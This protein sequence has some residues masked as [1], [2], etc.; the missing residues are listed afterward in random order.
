MD[1]NLQ[2]IVT[3]G[4]NGTSSRLIGKRMEKM[5][6]KKKKIAKRS[7]RSDTHKITSEN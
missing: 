4:S 6:M 3:I 2:P 1:D 5:A 7:K